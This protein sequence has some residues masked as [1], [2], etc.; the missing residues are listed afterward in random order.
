MDINP[1]NTGIGSG[2][3]SSFPFRKSVKSLPS[4]DELH[5]KR[6]AE[7]QHLR[8][9]KRQELLESRRHILSKDENVD[10]FS[11]SEQPCLPIFSSSQ[12]INTPQITQQ[13]PIEIGKIYTTEELQTSVSKLGNLTVA[14]VEKG[15]ITNPKQ[16]Q[17]QAV[18]CGLSIA[19]SFVGGPVGMLVRYTTDIHGHLFD[20]SQ[21]PTKPTDFYKAVNLIN[22]SEPWPNKANFF[23]DVGDSVQGTYP[24]GYGLYG[25]QLGFMEKALGVDATVI[26]NHDRNLNKSVRGE[27]N[28]LSKMKVLG[29]DGV[30]SVIIEKPILNKD[31]TPVKTRVA[32]IGLPCVSDFWPKNEESFIEEVKQQ[33]AE[34]K[35]LKAAGLIDS[36]FVLSHNGGENFK[37]SNEKDKLSINEQLAQQDLGIDVIFGGHDHWS[38][39]A[40]SAS[41]PETPVKIGDTYIVNAGANADTIHKLNLT[42]ENGHIT[43]VSDSLEWL[44]SGGKMPYERLKGKFNPN[45]APILQNKKDE[46]EEFYA[47]IPGFAKELPKDQVGALLVDK[48]RTSMVSQD[49]PTVAFL[50]SENLDT[51]GLKAY[52]TGQK[53]QITRFKE[54]YQSVPS[55]HKVVSIE[56]DKKDYKSMRAQMKSWNSKVYIA[57]PK[58]KLG[59]EPN[60]KVIVIAD[61]FI[62]SVLKDFTSKTQVIMSGQPPVKQT[63]PYFLKDTISADKEPLKN[64]H[65][66]VSSLSNSGKEIFKDDK[67]ISKSKK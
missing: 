22:N 15:I 28:N 60:T 42:V 26:G 61:E 37:K 13:T 16:L 51:N 9:E 67:F 55:E 30:N 40:L 29:K 39:G 54:V 23:F 33:A 36:I 6:E 25:H 5:K 49:K 62:A 57:K 4:Q 35:K 53:S 1:F 17:E 27:F 59:K 20:T 58:E 19:S 10:T 63:L 47:A 12:M 18:K 52:T 41:K 38:S 11:K 56:V 34:Y 2:V 64:L 24:E 46:F 43:G 48:M 21:K 32:I 31:N 50:H 7:L 45:M 65:G 44:G 66:R 8:N 3:G 14:S